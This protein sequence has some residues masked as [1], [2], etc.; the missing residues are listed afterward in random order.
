MIYNNILFFIVK[1]Y[2]NN[3]SFSLLSIIIMLIIRFLSGFSR[4]GGLSFF[5]FT[6]PIHIDVSPTLG[7]ITTTP[8][9]TSGIKKEALIFITIERGNIIKIKANLVYLHYHYNLEQ[10]LLNALIYQ[11][12]NYL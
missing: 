11:G 3:S 4:A 7:N 8:A 2:S 12:L 1:H 6:H 5:L 9:P 10:I